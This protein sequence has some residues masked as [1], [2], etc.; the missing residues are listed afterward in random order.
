MFSAGIVP[1]VYAVVN[2]ESLNH[3]PNVNPDFV[4][5]AGAVTVVPAPC[6]IAVTLL[7]PFDSNVMVYCVTS[8]VHLA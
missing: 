2:A 8:S 5:S 6:V 1:N 3:P 4:G 7:P